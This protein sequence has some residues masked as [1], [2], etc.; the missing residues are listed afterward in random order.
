[1]T[2]IAEVFTS[3]SPTAAI[4][5]LYVVLLGVLLLATCSKIQH[6]QSFI[7]VYPIEN[8]PQCT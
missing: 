4:L 5:T 8:E 6:S 3:D 7:N 1:M 2:K